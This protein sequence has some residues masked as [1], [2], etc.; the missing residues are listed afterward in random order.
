MNWQPISTA[1]KDGSWI[2]LCGGE[3]TEDD[4]DPQDDVR[5][6][7]PVSAF[8]LAEKMHWAFCYWDG[9][10]REGYLNPTHWCALELPEL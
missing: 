6:R 10:W 9:A 3:T 8:W 5:K 7:R 4:W 1:P 2:L